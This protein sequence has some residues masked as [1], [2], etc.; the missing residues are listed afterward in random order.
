MWFAVLTCVVL[1]SWNARGGE[2]KT[3]L[4]EIA[5]SQCALNVHSLSRSHKEMMGMKPDLKTNADCARYCVKERGG[6]FVL[7]TKSGDVYK[8]D[9]QALAEQWL[10]MKVKVVGT[11]DAK[12]S[13]ITVE[14]IAPQVA[15]SGGAGKPN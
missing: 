6:K 11:L 10:G 1:F 9:A 7:Q 3:F 5:D 4:G 15:S 14:S 12:T 13:L 2:A 8:L